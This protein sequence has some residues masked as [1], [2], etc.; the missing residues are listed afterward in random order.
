M[1]PYDYGH[2]HFEVRLELPFQNTTQPF[3]VPTVLAAS[4]RPEKG[5]WLIWRAEDDQVELLAEWKHK[6]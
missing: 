1:A 2:G 4:F 6:P 5:R 3:A